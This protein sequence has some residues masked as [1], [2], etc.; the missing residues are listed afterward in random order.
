MKTG[1]ALSGGGA[2]GAAHIGVLE[3]LTKNNIKIDQISGTSAGSIIAGIYASG[4]LE[5][6]NRFFEDMIKHD[7]FNPKKSFKIT[8]PV[9][10]FNLVFEQVNK[11]LVEDISQTKIP[12]YVASTDVESGNPVVFNSNQQGKLLDIIKS[13]CAYP[14]VFPIQNIANHN[15]IDGGITYNLPSL[16]LKNEVD[17]LIGS[18]LY[19]IYHLD[20]QSIRN[21]NSARILIRSIDII[22]R[23][24]AELYTKE[25]D[26]CFDMNLGNNLKWYS[27]NKIVPIREEGL[28]LAKRQLPK[29][30]KNLESKKVRNIPSK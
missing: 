23:Q 4:G 30:I 1:V 17:Y 19:G 21:F 2:L 3:T 7:V 5:A 16:P 28:K 22:Q 20:I 18:N 25:C 10:I 6:I 12:I 26:F 8:T 27:F 15:Y 9:K 24:L 13:S 29:L 14:G 11:Y